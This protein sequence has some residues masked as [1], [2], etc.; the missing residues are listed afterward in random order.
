[1]K[2]FILFLVLALGG[3]FAWRYSPISIR[4]QVRLM[5]TTHLIV[6]VGIVLIALGGL[7]AQFFFSSTQI[8]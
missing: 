1:L 4:N 5:L 7:V 3:Y 8:L 2:H 6:V